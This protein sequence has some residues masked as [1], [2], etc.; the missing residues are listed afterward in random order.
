MAN[1]AGLERIPLP[2]AAISL[3]HPIMGG[4]LGHQVQGLLNG[5]CCGFS[6]EGLFRSFQLVG[7]QSG[8]H[9]N[10]SHGAPPVRQ[11]IG[12]CMTGSRREV[13]S[14]AHWEVLSFE[15]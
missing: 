2:N 6:S 10:K 9:L 4:S 1:L 13:L 15:L 11:H 8:G 7:V 12:I 14:A 3:D 5:L